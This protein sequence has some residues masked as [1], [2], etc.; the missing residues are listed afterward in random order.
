MA[1]QPVLPASRLSTRQVECAVERAASA[2]RLSLMEQAARPVQQIQLLLVDHVLSVAMA[3]SQMLY[4]QLAYPVLPTKRAW[5]G[6]ACSFECLRTRAKYKRTKGVASSVIQASGELL[7]HSRYLADQQHSPNTDRSRCVR[8]PGNTISSD[9]QCSTTCSLNKLANQDHTSCIPCGTAQVCDACPVQGY[10]DSLAGRCVCEV[11][12][13][14]LSGSACV[15]DNGFV[16]LGSSI[17]GLSDLDV[18]KSR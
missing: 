15:C 10:F 3:P 18:H 13:A 6:R 5:A 4:D 16:A 1:A 9:G 14:S 2:K 11:A 8:C 17:E 12:N 7:A